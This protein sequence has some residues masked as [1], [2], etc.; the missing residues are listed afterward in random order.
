L[1]LNADSLFQ[2][3]RKL[4][5]VDWNLHFGPEY[6]GHPLTSVI[7]AT[8]AQIRHF[9]NWDKSK[10][11][12]DGRILLEIGIADVTKDT[13]PSDVLQ[14]VGRGDYFDFESD[15][16]ETMLAMIEVYRATRA[17]PSAIEPNP[18]NV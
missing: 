18:P 13:V 6:V 16:R 15:L 8:T 11:Q 10:P 2:Q 12:D 14:I 1:F 7:R 3:I 9:Y 5:G 4:L 17:M